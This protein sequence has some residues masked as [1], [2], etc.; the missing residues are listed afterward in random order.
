MFVAGGPLIWQFISRKSLSDPLGPAHTPFNV[1]LPHKPIAKRTPQKNQ[2]PENAFSPMLL[3]VF[4]LKV[5]FS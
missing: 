2:N 3:V 1:R 4:G 5:L